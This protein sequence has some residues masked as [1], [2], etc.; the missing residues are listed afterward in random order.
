MC[1]SRDV[2]DEAYYDGRVANEAR[3][4]MEEVKGGP[5][6]L[7][8]GFWKPHAPFNAPKKYWDLYDGKTLPALNPSRPE[9]TTDLA[10]HESTELLGIGKEKIT[11][12][13]EQILE[14]RRG[15]FANIS[16]LD[17]QIGKVLDALDQQG[18]A[19]NTIITFVGDNGYHI[20]EH[21]LWGK[22][23]NFEYDANVPLFVSVPGAKNAGAKTNAL[24]ELVDLFPT[25]LELCKLPKPD[26]LEGDSLV[27]ILNDPTTSIKRASFTQHPRPAYYDRVGD[28]LPQTMGYSVR[29]AKVRYTEWVDWKTKEV[30]AR[31]LYDDAQEPAEIRNRTDD[32]A[33]A[34]EQQEAAS[35]LHAQIKNQIAHQF[36][37]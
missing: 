36:Q 15:Y 1:E 11:L 6:F 25:L 8:V 19:S 20:G 23:T 2:P 9:G 3:R 35:L 7:A 14:W 21:Q 34:T 18:L 29:T 12:T 16:Y 37:K 31:E 22:T 5:F 26:G 4:V 27:P 17:A 28:H 24:S 32:P 33:L 13:P 30:V 10:F